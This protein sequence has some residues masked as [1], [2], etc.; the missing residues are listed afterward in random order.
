MKTGAE[1]LLIRLQVLCLMGIVA[2]QLAGKPQFA[3]LLF[4][5]TFF[6]TAALWA[7]VTARGISRGSL[8]VIG[9]LLLSG[10][11]VCGNAVCTG[12]VV[13]ASYLRKLVIFWAAVMQFGAMAEH[14]PEKKTVS[15]LL[16]GNTLQA[17]LLTAAYVLN[18]E[19]MYRIQG[20][21][22]GYLTFGFT[23]PNLA[24]AF[25][26]VMGMLEWI[27]A[28]TA[29]TGRA[30][31]LHR[32]VSGTL[33]FFVWETRARNAQL[34]LLCFFLMALGGRKKTTSLR[35]WA[36]GIAVLPLVFAGA[37]LLFLDMPGFQECFSFLAGEGKGLDSRAQIWRFALDA[38]GQSPVLGAFSQISQG[39]GASQMH[40]SHLDI[41]ASYGVPVLMLMWVFLT[42]ILQKRCQSRRSFL[43]MAGFAAMLLSGLGE[44]MLFS[45]GMGIGLYAGML[46]MLANF[47]EEPYEAGVSQQLV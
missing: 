19:D 42:L 39:T 11:A 7:A 15:L 6:L 20:V 21:V 29:R 33:T 18:R 30:Q 22:S 36:A 13:T 40:N 9:I 35:R 24:A 12:T 41:L 2:G 27:R 5:A 1:S 43:S 23:N 34:L 17:C 14:V 4:T 25:L 31:L 16:H 10:I 44:A 45:G 38:A 8:L 37:Y 3:S 26:C 47:E 46:R 28:E 32:M